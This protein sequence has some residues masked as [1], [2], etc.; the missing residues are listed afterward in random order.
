MPNFL[1]TEY[2]VNFEA[3][4]KEWASPHWAFDKGYIQ[5]PTAP[6]LGIEL[7]EGALAAHPSRP[8]PLRGFGDS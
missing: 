2:F 3:I 5:L 6:G 4:G 8:F 7:D 1:I